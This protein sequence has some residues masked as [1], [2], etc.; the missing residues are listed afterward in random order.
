METPC[1]L[2]ADHLPTETGKLIPVDDLE[3]P[4]PSFIGMAGFVCAWLVVGGI[5][6]LTMTLAKLGS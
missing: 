1:T 3:I 4:T 6:W 2:P 5:I